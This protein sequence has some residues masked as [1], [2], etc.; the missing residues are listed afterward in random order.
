MLENDYLI[1]AMYALVGGMTG[2]KLLYLFIIRK[3]INWN[4]ILE[5]EYLEKWLGSG[6]VYFGGFLGGIL[7]IYIAGKIHKIFV[8]K[9]LNTAI[10]CLSA[11]QGFGRRCVLCVGG[12]L[13]TE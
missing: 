6:F 1:L 13:C 11:A 10:P 2:V 9:Y 3:Y 8:S 5:I 4:R 7:G 12:K